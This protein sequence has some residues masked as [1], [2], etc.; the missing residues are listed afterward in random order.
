MHIKSRLFGEAEI[1]D[2]KIIEFTQG[3]MGF[4]EYKKYAII[5]DSERENAGGIMWLQS[6]DDPDIAFPMVNPVDIKPDYNPIVEDEWLEPLG[7][8]E[9]EEE[10][11]VLLVLTV[12]SDLTKTTCNMK[13]P[14]IINTNTRKACQLIV[15]NEDYLVRYNIY[16]FIEKLKKE[17]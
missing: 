11:F 3:M 2:D 9:N 7:A 16:D 15:N 13:A 12:P 17:G 8:F 6:L 10:L 5:F 14:V 1:D 4:E